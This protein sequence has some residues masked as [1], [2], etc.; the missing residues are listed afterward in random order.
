MLPKITAAVCTYNRF[1][2]LP[3]SLASL[4][5]Q[6]LRADEYEILIVDN[7][8]DEAAADAFWTKTELPSNCR[9]IRTSPPGLSRARNIA[10]KEAKAPIIAYLDDD[11]I[12]ADTWLETYIDYFENNPK[13]GT[14]GGPVEP[15]W[16]SQKPDWLP[17][18][19]LGCLT[20]LDYG[21]SDKV[22]DESG[23]CFGANLA[24]RRATLEAVGGFDETIGRIGNASLLS[25]EEIVVQRKIVEQ[26]GLRKGYCSKASV[27][28]HVDPERLSHNWFRSRMAWQAVSEILPGAAGG[29]SHEW[30]H[31]MLASSAEALGLEK[32]LHRF[33]NPKNA[34]EFNQQLHF[35]RH[36]IGEMLHAKN[37]PDDVNQTIVSRRSSQPVD[38]TPSDTA[39]EEI[40]ETSIVLPKLG[41]S[42]PHIFAEFNPGHR[43]LFDAYGLSDKTHL[44]ILKDNPWTT[45]MRYSLDELAMSLNKSNQSVTF[46]SLDPFLQLSQISS[47][48]QFLKKLGVPVFGILHRLPV[49]SVETQNLKSLDQDLGGIFVLSRPFKK[50]VEETLGLK[51]LCYVPHHPTKFQFT[52]IASDTF[53]K[54]IGVTDDQILISLVGELRQHKGLETLL[55]ALP[56]L[57]DNA[58]KRLV[59]LIAG[60][61]SH[62]DIDAV[63][64]SFIEANCDYRIFSGKGTGE[65]YI[66]LNSKQFTEIL[67]A[68]DVGL[69]LYEDVQKHL[70]SGILPD[71][72]WLGKTVITT[73]TSM[74][75]QEMC[76]HKAGFV[77]AE[78]NPT[79]LAKLFNGLEHNNICFNDRASY[80]S[81][82]NHI[83]PENAC[84]EMVSVLDNV[85]GTGL[86]PRKGGK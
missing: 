37:V 75:G 47:F 44:T 81:L 86:L 28:H 6:S 9:L 4:S 32:F 46:L 69:L 83:S 78:R 80:Q 29:Y 5:T 7:S 1:S 43:Y 39:I 40:S 60:K 23:F 17:H 12:A 65:S 22:L 73:A 20:I 56:K 57:D 15:I 68:T 27:R 49:N 24:F 26:A 77:V 74:A 42:R 70:T 51:S 33:M 55:A 34:T 67:K 45:P 66:Y 71:F 35:L 50:L 31:G 76:T 79:M 25:N 58:K 10:T 82:Q 54:T 8:D 2:Y 3:L 18:S 72:I 41:S 84:H 16:P 85:T 48:R 38:S 59:F 62:Y 13:V 63:E 11:A 64:R 30:N 19:F 52:N 21:E 36:F 61:S 14:A 53:R